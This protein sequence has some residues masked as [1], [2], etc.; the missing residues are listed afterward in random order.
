MID[1]RPRLTLADALADPR[2]SH[3]RA[4]PFCG[5]YLVT[6]YRREPESPSGVIGFGPQGRRLARD[7][8]RLPGRRADV[9]TL[10]DGGPKPVAAMTAKAFAETHAKTELDTPSEV[11]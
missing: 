2:Y 8:G 9:A 5:R 3:A 1:A 4:R 11:R 6:L 7:G 10:P